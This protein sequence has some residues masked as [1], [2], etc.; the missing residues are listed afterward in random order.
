MIYPRQEH[1]DISCCLSCST[2][3]FSADRWS[4]RREKMNYNLATSSLTKK[5]K[6]YGI[7]R[8]G[9][10]IEKILGQERLTVKR[11]IRKLS[12][13]K[14]DKGRFELMPENRVEEKQKFSV[15]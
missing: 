6:K 2:L 5:R 14:R 9:K 11:L 4:H 8:K 7:L 3:W 10:L 15:V 12:S 13:Y 1:A